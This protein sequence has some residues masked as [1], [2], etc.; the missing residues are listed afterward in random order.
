VSLTFFDQT[1][2]LLSIVLAAVIIYR[3]IKQ[4]LFTSPFNSFAVMLGV[5]L[6]RDAAVSI[7]RYDSHA[8]TAVWEVSLPVLLLAQLWVGFDALLAIAR[9]YVTFG[10]FAA[11]LYLWCLGA[12][13]VLCGTTLPRE[14]ARVS[15][16]EALLREL[17]LLQRCIDS[18]IAG[19]LILASAFLLLHLAPPCRPPRNLVV[20]TILLSLY[21]AGYSGLF[22]VE[23]LTVL[24]GAAIAERIQFVLIVLLYA[25]WARALS[26][27]GATSEPWPQVDVV[28][29]QPAALSLEYEN[30]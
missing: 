13:I 26:K 10:N 27:Q 29:L 17:F 4:R 5:V 14:L 25:G 30:R 8:Y 11:R 12:S 6:A 19:T 21:F 24:G 15:G 1:L 2:R 28:V 9:L 22:F 3:I 23:N 7:P 20:H 16:Q 18:L